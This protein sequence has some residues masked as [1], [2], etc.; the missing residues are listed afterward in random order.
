MVKHL[1]YPAKKN[2]PAEKEFQP[3]LIVH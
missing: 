2:N 1:S 3:G